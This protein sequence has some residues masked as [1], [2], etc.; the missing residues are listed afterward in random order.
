MLPPTFKCYLC[1][2][3]AKLVTEPREVGVGQR[4]VV[5]EDTFYRCGNCDETFYLGGMADE[6]FR[7][8]AAA[9]RKAEGL[10][11][12][13]AIRALRAKYGLSQ[14]E[15]EKLIGA[16]EK[17][18]VRWERGTVAQNATA[19]TLLR[20]LRALPEA[21]ALLAKERGVKVTLPPAENAPLESDASP[22]EKAA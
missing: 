9:V 3:A 16:G 13:D 14:A 21:V 19:D 1:G 17:T 12:P 4:K 15:L 6:S 22:V 5:I 18:V 10:L 2:T 20:V 8:G 11:E 7:R